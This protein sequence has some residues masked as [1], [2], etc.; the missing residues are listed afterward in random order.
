MLPPPPPHSLLVLVVTSYRVPYLY[1]LDM[2]SCHDNEVIYNYHS[3]SMGHIHKLLLS[4]H[5]VTITT[6]IMYYRKNFSCKRDSQI[7]NDN[8]KNIAEHI[9]NLSA[10][11]LG[12]G[13]IY[14]SLPVQTNEAAPQHS[15]IHNPYSYIYGLFRHY[16]KIFIIARH[17]NY[18]NCLYYSIDKCMR[19]T[20]PGNCIGCGVT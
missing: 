18:I 5:S 15:I 12:P 11:V 19:T 1:A 16:S 9:S 14:L 4:I 8:K 6:I 3:G 13:A 20:E 7:K 10:I 2:Y 17:Q